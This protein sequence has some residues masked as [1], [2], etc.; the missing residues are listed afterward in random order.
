MPGA[1]VCQELKVVWAIYQAQP[2]EYSVRFLDSSLAAHD[3][4]ISLVRTE[5]CLLGWRFSANLLS[6]EDFSM[7]CNSPTVFVS[8]FV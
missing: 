8:R 4:G 5:E 1:A 7:K 3:F 2:K 6:A